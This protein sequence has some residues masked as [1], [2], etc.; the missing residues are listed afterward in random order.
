MLNHLQQKYEQWRDANP[1]IM[2]LYRRFALQ[3]MAHK[4]KFSI[5][6]LTERVRWEC[7]VRGTGVFKVNNNYRAYIA[8]DLAQQ[9]P[10][11]DKFIETRRVIGEVA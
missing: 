11:L 5:S 4:V 3:L 10:D 7:A 9:I 2:S 1:K 8:R 6:L